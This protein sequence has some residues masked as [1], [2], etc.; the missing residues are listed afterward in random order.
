LSKE[1]AAISQ[2]IFARHQADTVL[3]WELHGSGPERLPAAVFHHR[4]VLFSVP[5]AAVVP[6]CLLFQL[7]AGILSHQDERDTHVDIV[8]GDAEGGRLGLILCCYWVA[9][10]RFATAT[11]SL[12]YLKGLKRGRFFVSNAPSQRRYLE[13]FDRTL[14]AKRSPDWAPILPL[15]QLVFHDLNF[16]PVVEIAVAHSQQLVVLPAFIVPPGPAAGDTASQLLPPSPSPSPSLL[17]WTALV[18]DPLVPISGDTRIRV[19]ARSDAGEPLMF[20]VFFHTNFVSAAGV[21]FQRPDLDISM[22]G[23]QVIRSSFSMSLV[24]D[25][26]LDPVPPPSEITQTFHSTIR[27]FRS[28]SGASQ[29]PAL[30]APRSP[31]RHR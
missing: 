20:E 19:F 8:T 5:F 18:F 24:F 23:R 2:V 21:E 13:Y 11:D 16:E 22:P 7:L 14:R 12:S 15:K 6:L 28:F 27:R 17:A 25:G 4:M 29:P 26:S 3:I 10:G 1:I 31:P 30:V 9:C